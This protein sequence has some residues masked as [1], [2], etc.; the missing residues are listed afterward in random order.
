MRLNNV[1]EELLGSKPKIK[2][3]RALF[4]VNV[5][6]TGRKVALLSGL[7]HRTCLLSL[8]EL[9]REGFISIRSAGKA[10]LYTLNLENTYLKNS[11][12]KI[13]QDEKNLIS[14][15]FKRIKIKL[16]GKISTLI[17]FGSI[18]EGKEQP[19]SDI[20]ICIVVKSLLEKRKIEKIIK[21]ETDRIMKEYGNDLSCYYITKN[22][23]IKK[24]KRKDKLISEIA[25]RGKII[26]G[27]RFF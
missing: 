25:K 14:N 4:K 22:N 23:F 15:L 10:K 21:N 20:D 3:L 6:L 11:I 27:E 16:K 1:I 24:Y 12:S 8:R 19:D 9:S 17:L 2:I 18:V 26:G 13:F 5:P 7:N